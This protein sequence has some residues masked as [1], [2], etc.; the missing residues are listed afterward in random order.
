[1]LPARFPSR[2]SLR[3]RLTILFMAVIG[4]LLT[5]L[6][7][8]LPAHFEQVAMERLRLR[9]ESLASLEAFTV[10]SAVLF[11]DSITVDN[12]LQGLLGNDEVHYAQISGANGQILGATGLRPTD[13]DRDGISII[14]VQVPIVLDGHDL[15]HVDL[16]MSTASVQAD[17]ATSHRYIA[18]LSV[19]IFLIGGI[20]VAIISTTVTRSLSAIV[21]ATERI[22]DGD[23]SS[24][25]DEALL[26]ETGL[27]ARSFN[28]MVDRVQQAQNE[29]EIGN[30]LLER[31]LDNLPLEVSLL[32]LSG[33][34]VYVNP[35]GVE[36]GEWRKWLIGRTPQQYL[37]HRG[38]RF[39]GDELPVDSIHRSVEERRLIEVEH[40]VASPDGTTRHL[41]CGYRPILDGTGKPRQVVSFTVDVTARRRAEEAL[42]ESEA[43]LRQAQ[44]ME[45]VGRLAGGVAH[46]FNNLLTSISG[47][48]EVAL[49]DLEADS[50]VRDDLIQIRSSA[51]RAAELTRQLLAFSRKQVIA[52][53]LLAVNEVVNGLDGMLRPLIGEDVVLRTVLSE[54]R[55]VVRADANQLE[56]V[57][58]N[59]VINARDAMPDGGDLTVET[60]CVDLRG[61]VIAAEGLPPGR[62]VTIVVSDTGGG[63]DTDTLSRIFDPFF[64]SKAPGEGTGLGLATVYGIVQQNG[65]SI[66]V[67]SEIDMGSVF[68]VYLP[69]VEGE[70]K[71][72]PIPAFEPRAI[73]GHETV[74]VVEDQ[75]AVRDATTKILARYGYEVLP[76]ASGREG[77]ELA[78][79]S[80]PIDLVLTDVM[81]PDMG[82]VE[83][84]ERLRAIRPEV[85]VLYMS[86]YTGDALHH[87]GVLEPGVALLEKPF[88]ADG[89]CRAVR[90]G[91]DQAQEVGVR[92]EGAA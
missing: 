62:Y 49:L 57:I 50:S 4:I 9:A 68:R 86:G 75:E 3:G 29:L 91:L 37:Q 26:G 85:P 27:L 33:R 22:A 34:Y 71:P 74:L 38:L 84:T 78:K 20:A 36:E 70:S 10:R 32:D 82:G 48:C 25:A 16:Q 35:A 45:S 66:S 72:A 65:G 81:M 87:R 53:R 92:H 89:L 73:A 2:S 90:S 83:F 12:A 46:D 69:A 15:G 6:Y 19:V 42:K 41:R 61:Q 44:K 67:Y 28:R 47:H 8:V 14:A 13:A 11:Q 43:K 55:G 51:A 88:T 23:L 5:V 77:L 39:E 80:Q 24:R 30:R 1:M 54:D 64:T 40:Q 59:L 79:S 56:Q 60:S 31:I 52:P 76:C 21:V 58:L 18:L 63:M 17:V 7:L